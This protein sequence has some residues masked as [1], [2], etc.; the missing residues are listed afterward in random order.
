MGLRSRE[1]TAEPAS[2]AENRYPVCRGPF[3]DSVGGKIAEQKETGIDPDGTLNEAEAAG[4]LFDL[5]AGGTMRSNSAATR[6]SLPP[7]A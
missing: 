3:P 6:T 2:L 4:Q 1:G 7:C 5:R